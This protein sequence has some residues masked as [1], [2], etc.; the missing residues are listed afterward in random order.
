ML[1]RLVEVS[2]H[3]AHR[4]RERVGGDPARTED[5]IL[6]HLGRCARLRRCDAG[7]FIA[8]PARGHGGPRLLLGPG[9]TRP[10]AVI[11]VMFGALGRRAS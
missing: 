11:T 1:G 2:T 8:E 7:G 4:W 9:K 10:V 5:E 3:A 6:E